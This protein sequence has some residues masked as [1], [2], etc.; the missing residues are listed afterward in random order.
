MKI[1]TKMFPLHGQKVLLN[2]QTLTIKI[3]KISLNKKDSKI[4]RAKIIIKFSKI[5][6][7]ILDKIQQ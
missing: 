6:R 1:L 3:S 4:I 2:N 7:K 5:T